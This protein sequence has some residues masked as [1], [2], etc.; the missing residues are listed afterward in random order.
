MVW[1]GVLA[2]EFGSVCARD[3]VDPQIKTPETKTPA[4]R[5]T[6]RSQLRLKGSLLASIFRG[7]G[8]EGKYPSLAG[9]FF[10]MKFGADDFDAAAEAN[11]RRRPILAG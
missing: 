5:K 9:Y 6:R 1:P 10:Q 11:H 3:I 4:N 8:T 7:C 2:P